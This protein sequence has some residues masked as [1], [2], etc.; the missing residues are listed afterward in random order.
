MSIHFLS[1]TFCR[2]Q[3]KALL[4]PYQFGYQI[5]DKDGNVQHRHEESDADGVKRGSYG[6]VD[7]NG[8]Y[9][10]VHYIADKNGFRVMEMKSNEP[11]LDPTAKPADIKSREPDNSHTSTSVVLQTQK[12]DVMSYE[13]ELNNRLVKQSFGPSLQGSRVK[14]KAIIRPHNEFI[15]NPS[16]KQET[17]RH[18]DARSDSRPFHVS[19]AIPHFPDLKSVPS[20]FPYEFV[21]IPP[22]ASANIREHNP[23]LV[24]SSHSVPIY[25]SVKGRPEPDAY[26]MPLPLHSHR[27]PESSPKF[28]ETTSPSKDNYYFPN[29]NPSPVITERPVTSSSYA[30]HFESSRLSHLRTSDR[31]LTPSYR[32]PDPPST[33]SGYLHPLQPIRPSSPKRPDYDY[34]TTQTPYRYLIPKTVN[35]IHDR[36]PYEKSDFEKQSPDMLYPPYISSYS[37]PRT[38]LRP[39]V[40]YSAPASRPLESEDGSSSRDRPL[41]YLD[42]PGPGAIVGSS[43]MEPSVF[44][45]DEPFDSEKLVNEVF[46]YA[47]HRTGPE[48]PPP[49]SGSSGPGG[50]YGGYGPGYDSEPLPLPPIPMPP[51]VAAATGGSSPEDSSTRQRLASY[52]KSVKNSAGEKV[53][54]QDE[55][56]SVLLGIQSALGL[57]TGVKA[58][59][60]DGGTEQENYTPSHYPSYQQ[61]LLLRKGLKNLIPLLTT[62]SRNAITASGSSSS[63]V[64]ERRPDDR[65]SS[66]T[67]G[68]SVVY[69]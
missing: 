44:Y 25:Q 46:S 58:A 68:G 67:S 29:Y 55:V 1:P 54:S 21:P 56:P 52:Y 35:S 66:L 59:G 65:F 22:R 53:R 47:P 60:S 48:P 41:Q 20:S 11:G 26:H 4:K 2:I 15:D 64:T 31:H 27:S 8:V 57:E 34:T 14:E 39:Y 7:A 18:R 69:Q 38:T 36:P 10:K 23:N 28:A 6:Y 16:F 62:K 12:P 19:S 13:R 30:P 9:R 24:Q 40:S 50:G 17:E 49:D 42:G 37:P 61:I 63:A 32:P 33:T 3:D 51:V 43:R 5:K 45:S